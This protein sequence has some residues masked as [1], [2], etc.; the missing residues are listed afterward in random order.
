MGRSKWVSAL[1]CL[2]VV[3][4]SYRY[5]NTVVRGFRSPFTYGSDIE[6][7]AIWIATALVLIILAAALKRA[8]EIL[9]CILITACVLILILSGTFDAALTVCGILLLAH[10]AGRR[11]LLALGAEPVPILAM[12]AGLVALALGGFVLAAVHAL[13][14]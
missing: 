7:F 8:L 13:T 4:I 9:F 14:V 6:W 1:F 12:P 11:V 10:L 2:W 5:V 3:V